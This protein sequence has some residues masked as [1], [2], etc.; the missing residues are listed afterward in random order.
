LAPGELTSFVEGD[1]EKTEHTIKIAE[2][3]VTYQLPMAKEHID[4]ANHVLDLH[5]AGCPAHE[6]IKGAIRV[7]IK[8]EYQ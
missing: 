4:L 6:S 8:A 2:I 7:K 5:P 3:R 1:I